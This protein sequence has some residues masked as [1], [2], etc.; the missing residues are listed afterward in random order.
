MKI[1]LLLTGL[2]T[3][4]TIGFLSNPVQ[5]SAQA[6]TET[7]NYDPIVINSN[8]EYSRK[9]DSIDNFKQSQIKKYKDNV[10]ESLEI[11]KVKEKEQE[12]LYLSVDS[13]YSA[14]NSNTSLK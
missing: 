12:K 1:S 5:P 3:V 2:L 13:L 9:L 10:E 14:I 6:E 8:L 11:V 4:G 7:S